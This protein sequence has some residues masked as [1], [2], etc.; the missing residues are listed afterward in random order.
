VERGL[1]DVKQIP[2]CKDLRIEEQLEARFSEST[3]QG[4]LATIHF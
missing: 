3:H 4:S 1:V 2:H